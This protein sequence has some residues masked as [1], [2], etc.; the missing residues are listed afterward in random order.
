MSYHKISPYYRDIPTVAYCGRDENLEPGV[1]FGPVIRD[2]Y[3][4]ECCFSGYG[5]VIIN[6]KKHTVGPGDV[7]FLMPG[8]L[9]MH[10][11][12]RKEPR[13]GVYCCVDGLQVG[14]ALSEAGIST[15]NPFAPPHV[16]DAVYREIEEIVSLAND[17]SIGAEFRRTACIYRIF[18]ALHKDRKKNDGYSLV[19]KAIGMMETQYETHLTVDS[20]AAAVGL[21]R[22][23]FS[24]LF[25]K[26][27]G[28]APHEYLNM[29]RIKKACTLIKVYDYPISQAAEKVGLDTAN[30]ARTFKKITGKTP[31]EY[32]NESENG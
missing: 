19:T 20:L 15:E 7:Y 22:S 5:G 10:T 32:K 11:A 30:F 14:R 29:L 13:T 26:R 21:D 2:V 1:T 4:F 23:Y 31:R 9:I 12:D 28:Y 8:D 25:K 3:V 24:T 18:A 6:G 17:D 16:F 27:T